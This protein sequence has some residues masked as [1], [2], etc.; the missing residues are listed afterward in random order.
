MLRADGVELNLPEKFDVKVSKWWITEN[1]VKISAK[2]VDKIT[3]APIIFHFNENSFYFASNKI[4]YLS[5]GGQRDYSS[6]SGEGKI[7]KGKLVGKITSEN[8]NYYKNILHFYDKYTSSL[9]ATIKSNGELHIVDTST[10]TSICKERE[11]T[12]EGWGALK[13]CS[14]KIY[15][16][17]YGGQKK[18]QTHMILQLPI[19]QSQSSQAFIPDSLVEP[20]PIQEQLQPTTPMITRSADAEDSVDTQIQETKPKTNYDL[21]KDPNQDSATREYCANKAYNRKLKE[22][23]QEEE[24]AEEKSERERQRQ[25]EAYQNMLSDWYE[26]D[27]QTNI[28]FV[29]G[30]DGRKKRSQEV[31]ARAN[32]AFHDSIAKDQRERKAKQAEIKIAHDIVDKFGDS[33]D[34]QRLSHKKIEELSRDADSEKATKIKNIMRKQY[35][36]SQQIKTQGEA[37]Y[38]IAKAKE[39]G[40]KSKY[41]ETIKDTSLTINKGLAKL[42]PT[43]TGDKIVKV[44]EHAYAGVDGYE[45]GGGS[46]LV[47]KVMD[48]HTNGMATQTVETAQE[49]HDLH[50]KGVKLNKD[51]KFYDK[52]GKRLTV[53]KSGDKAYATAKGDKGEKKNFSMVSRITKKAL[54]KVDE[55][56]NPQTKVMNSLKNIKD[57]ITEGDFNKVANGAMDAVDIKDNLTGQLSDEKEGD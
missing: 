20:D 26:E 25:E 49:Y 43:G 14:G 55:T 44:M 30:L 52:D 50:T 3:S 16:N 17:I 51:E 4:L 15:D 13:I 22:K 37:E 1:G 18:F 8:W 41:V 21:C 33:Y 45:K 54:E 38:Q 56:Y 53:I 5:I 29:K 31:E 57:G 23:E 11:W 7:I 24:I 48:I 27:H 34:Q 9:T 12:E 10:I 6:I 36:D 35:F 2:T 32:R 47:V 28:K 39:I 40:K 19:N 42:D 46:G